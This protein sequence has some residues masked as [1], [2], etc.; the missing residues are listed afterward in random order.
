MF[1]RQTEFPDPEFPWYL[2]SYAPFSTVVKIYSR[3]KTYEEARDPC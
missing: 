1:I 2:V 3:H